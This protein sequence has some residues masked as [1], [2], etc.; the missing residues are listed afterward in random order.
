MPYQLLNILIATAI[1][2]GRLVEGNKTQCR[3]K[4]NIQQTCSLSQRE[5]N[6]LTDNHLDENTACT[7]MNFRWIKKLNTKIKV[8][9]D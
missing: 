3:W 2:I 7:G 4:L 1:G 6:S 8:L 9:R 5:K